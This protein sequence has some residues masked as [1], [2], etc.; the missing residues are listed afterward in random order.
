M[1]ALS[2]GF[3][4]D[5]FER[6]LPLPTPVRTDSSPAVVRSRRRRRAVTSS[7]PTAIVAE[8]VPRPCRRI[9][10]T[11]TLWWTSGSERVAPCLL[12]CPGLP[13]A[14]RVSGTARRLVVV[15]WLADGGTIDHCGTCRTGRRHERRAGL[16]SRGVTHR[17]V[18]AIRLRNRVRLRDPCRRRAQAQRRCLPRSPGSRA[19]GGR[20]RHGRDI[21][22]ATSQAASSSRVS[23]T[24]HRRTTPSA[25]SARCARG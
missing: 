13:A 21:R 6:P 1:S 15:A 8:P 12:I 23:A 11:R 17:H 4:L 19:L 16:G 25:S 22:P 7:S 20:R 3:D 14:R 10:V 24:S 9:R 2:D 5:N 18:P